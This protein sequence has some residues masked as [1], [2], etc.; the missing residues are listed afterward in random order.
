MACVAEAE[1]IA[2]YDAAKNAGKI[3]EIPH[4][5]LVN[6]NIVYPAEVHAEAVCSW[7]GE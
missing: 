4:S 5:R 1:W 7:T 3:P 2:S 6:G